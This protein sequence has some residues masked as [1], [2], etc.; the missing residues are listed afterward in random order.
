MTHMGNANTLHFVIPITFSRMQVRVQ[1]RLSE[2]LCV[3]AEG[4]GP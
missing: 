4:M 3:E 1:Y 2:C